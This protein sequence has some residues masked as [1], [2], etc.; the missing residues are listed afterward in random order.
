MKALFWGRSVCDLT[1]KINGYPA[2]NE[3]IFAEDFLIQPGGTA[4]NPAVTFAMLAG[5]A[6][7]ISS[8]GNGILAE[9]IKSNLEEYNIDLLNLSIN[10]NFEIPVSA[11]FIN[12]QNSS[13]TIINS[14]EINNFSKLDIDR[15]KNYIDK[16]CPD[17]IQIDGFDLNNYIE[18]LKY[19]KK[20]GIKIVF[21]GG[22]WKDNTENFISLVDIA[23]C[24]N[25]FR[26]PSLSIED[27]IFKLHELGVANVAVTRDEKPIISSTDYKMELIDVE[28]VDAV[29]SLGAGDV[30]HGAF[31]YYYLRNSNFKEALSE[32]SRIASESCRYFGTHTWG[33]K[34]K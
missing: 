19:A 34:S 33:Q 12:S 13:R 32:A 15:L 7:L 21:D 5:K 29:D 3:K 4:L 27:T 8:L 10:G 28:K 18:V 6:H 2:E 23:I 11:V 22:S 1:Y 9:K 20:K 26:F 14:P 30:L 31:C 17:L 24:S 25:R 16:I